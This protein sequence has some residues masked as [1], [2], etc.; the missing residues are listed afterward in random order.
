MLQWVDSEIKK[1]GKIPVRHILHVDL[2]TLD[3]ERVRRE[4]TAA[5]DTINTCDPPMRW[6]TFREQGLAKRPN[7]EEDKDVAQEGDGGD[8][9]DEGDIMMFLMRYP[10]PDPDFYT[11]LYRFFAG[12]NAKLMELGLGKVQFCLEETIASGKIG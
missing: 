3:S 10:G 7:R 11:I 2:M 9:G 4:L 12:Y 6:Y 8:E 5:L 1:P